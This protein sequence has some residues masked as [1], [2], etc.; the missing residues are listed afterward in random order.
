ME[1]LHW[2]YVVCTYYDGISNNLTHKIKATVLQNI[3]HS[4]VDSDNRHT[5]NIYTQTKVKQ[6]AKLPT[7]RAGTD[8]PES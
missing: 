1:L 3:F 5:L 8:Y 2:I 7:S 6:Y 4:E